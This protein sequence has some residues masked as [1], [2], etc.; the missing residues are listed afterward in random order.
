MYEVMVEGVFI[1]VIVEV[2]V[3]IGDG[4]SEG[5]YEVVGCGCVR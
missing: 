4:G 2:S 3:M 1:K 5:V